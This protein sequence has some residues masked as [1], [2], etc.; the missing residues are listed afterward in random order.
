MVISFENLE[1]SLLI[2]ISCTI[3]DVGFYDRTLSSAIGLSAC[4]REEAASHF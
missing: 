3:A 2:K 4:K 1:E